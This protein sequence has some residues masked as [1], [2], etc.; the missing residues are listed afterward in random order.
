MENN[1]EL[2]KKEAI[3]KDN[4]VSIG[5]LEIDNIKHK[6]ELFDKLALIIKQS[7]IEGEDYGTIPNCDKPSLFKSGAEKI[8][9][10]YGLIAKYE[11]LPTNNPHLIK[12]NCKL[13]IAK[14]NQFVAESF[15]LSEVPKFGKDEG[16]KYNAAYKMCQKRA[17]VGA[18]VQIANLSKIFTQDMEDF[19]K[20]Q[21]EKKE[22]KK[23][24][25]DMKNECKLKVNQL[26]EK[27]EQHGKKWGWTELKEDIKEF[28]FVN[29]KKCLGIYAFYEENSYLFNSKFWDFLKNKYKV[30]DEKEVSVEESFN[31]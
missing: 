9:L 21:Q 16:W 3:S 28:A 19:D 23:V 14:T 10:L 7:L 30:D 15:G 25:K 11:E 26:I 27:M 1:K 5:S 12:I 22:L 6:L 4:A 18:I 17:F 24:D 20:K 2:V 13:F 8:A 29:A 31:F